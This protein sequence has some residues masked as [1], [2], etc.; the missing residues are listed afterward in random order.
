MK[1]YEMSF[2]SAYYYKRQSIVKFIELLNN[3]LG[4]CFVDM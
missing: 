4:K 3:E 1:V 2:F